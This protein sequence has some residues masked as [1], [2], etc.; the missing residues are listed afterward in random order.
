[1]HWS[2]QTESACRRHRSA[3]R[4]PR[5]LATSRQRDR[6]SLADK[7]TQLLLVAQKHHIE[8]TDRSNEGKGDRNGIVIDTHTCMHQTISKWQLRER[9]TIDL[10][11]QLRVIQLQLTSTLTTSCYLLNFSTVT[12][13]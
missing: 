13:L 5:N 8:Q 3:H 7:Q 6:L 9:E 11:I 12:K 10:S 4:G 2:P 1:M